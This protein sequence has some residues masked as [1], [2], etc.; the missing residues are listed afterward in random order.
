MYMPTK[1]QATASISK[2]PRTNILS[3]LDIFG[4]FTGKKKKSLRI[5]M[6]ARPIKTDPKFVEFVAQEVKDFLQ[7]SKSEHLLEDKEGLKKIVS[8]GIS[9]A[10]GRFYKGRDRKPSRE[11]ARASVDDVVSRLLREEEER[12][13]G[14]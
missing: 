11:E 3:F 13:L 8:D 12:K 7:K 1:N 2:S 14:V 5:S 6:V 10:P 4:L 9:T